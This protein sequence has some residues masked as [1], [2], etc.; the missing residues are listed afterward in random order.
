MGLL[1][2]SGRS[3]D[4]IA[5]TPLRL[6]VLSGPVLKDLERE[7]RN[8]PAASARRSSGGGRGFSRRPERPSRTTPARP[9]RRPARSRASTSPPC[10]SAAWRTI[11]RPRPEPGS[12][13]RVVGAVE[14]V[15]H[16]RQVGLVEA[17]A[18]GRARSARRRRASISTRPPPRAPLE[19][20]VDAG[21]TRRAG[22]GRARR[23]RPSGSVDTS[24][25]TP[26]A[27]RARPV[28][29]R[30]R[31]SRRAARRPPP[32]PASRRAP[33]RRCRPRARS[34]RPAPR[35]CRRGA[36]RAP[37]RGS[38]SACSSVWM[39]A[40]R[41]AIGVRSSWLASATRWRC[42]STERS[43]ASSVVLKLRAS[44]PSS[45]FAGHVDP[46]RGVRIAGDLLGAAREAGDR[47]ERGARHHARRARRRAPR[48]RR[49]PAAAPAARGRAARSTSSSGR[50]TW[51]APPRCRRRGSG[52]ARACRDT[53]SSVRNSPGRCARSRASRGVHREARR[54]G[55]A[56]EHARPTGARAARS[57]AAPPNGSA[58][59]RECA[60]RPSGRPP[61]P[62]GSS[63]P[64]PRSPPRAASARGRGRASE[65]STS[66]RSSARTP[67]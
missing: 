2:G 57:P 59:R 50:A 12:D 47:R 62:S 29:P 52:R 16:V 19:R 67:R 42:A 61:P 58:R 65:L 15:E 27:R 46:V 60:A 7:S 4:V 9:R 10:A 35:R 22:S 23:A 3:A 53:V 33:A 18:R 26:F 36:T 54:A 38:R 55:R 48:R 32:R 30:S 21:S 44:R 28:R 17:R 41:L 45:S 56:A 1:E 66:P 49:P 25:A 14:A 31:R 64:P 5:E 40:R 8:W 63:G 11:A 13:A 34:A 37:R 43:S 39:F 51:I 20:V 24:I 6:I